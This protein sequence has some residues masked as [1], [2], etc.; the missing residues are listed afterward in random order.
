VPAS[1]AVSAAVSAVATGARSGEPDRV[2][3]RFEQHGRVR[4]LLWG[5]EYA[6]LRSEVVEPIVPGRRSAA[7]A[8]ERDLRR[9]V[10]LS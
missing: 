9:G 10:R 7:V 6:G 2:Y 5:M 8:I 3:V 4:L 1:Q